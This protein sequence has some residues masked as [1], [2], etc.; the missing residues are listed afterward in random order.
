MKGYGKSTL[1]EALS[2]LA[3][4]PFY[5]IDNLI[6]HLHFEASKTKLHYSE[7][8]RR[9]GAQQFREFE[10]KAVDSVTNISNAVIATGGV[11]H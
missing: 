3:N 2:I 4:R 1:G 6:E 7:I 5:D 8:Y 9:I 10:Q 11:E